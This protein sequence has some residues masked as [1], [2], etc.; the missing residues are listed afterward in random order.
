MSTT[1][2]HAQ[3]METHLTS[4]SVTL[5]LSSAIAGAIVY[6]IFLLQPGYRGDPL[7]YTIVII[8]ELFLII[9][10]I[11]TFW[12]ILSGR[13]NP[14]NFGYHAAQDNLLGGNS[15]VTIKKLNKSSPTA[16][17]LQ[18]QIYIH[19][20]MVSI[21]VFIPVYGE[22]L[23]VIQETAM[24]AKNIYGKHST[25]I[26]DD[27]KSDDV[28]LMA[29]RIGVGYLRRPDNNDAKAGNIN[30]ALANTKGEYFIIFDADFVADKH[31]IVETIPFFEDEKMAFVQTPQYYDN[32]NN[33]ISTGANYMQHVFYSLVQV[34]KNRFNASFC[35]GTNVIFRR[36]A[37]ESIGGMYFQSK[38][39]DIWTS[40]LLHEKGYRSIYINKVLAIG[41]TPETIKAYT[42]QQ[43]RW[44]TGS[45]EILLKY[46]PLRN[47][48]LT[49][50]QRIQY[51][52]TT[53]F[54]LNG[55]AIVG[56]VLLPALQIYFNLTPISLEIP[57][58]Q[59]AILYSGFY[60]TQ[61]TLSILTMGAFR[62]ETIVLSAV[63]FPIYVKA[64]MN[65]FWNRD[66]TWR[67]TNRK[68]TYDSPFNYI[69][70]QTYLFIFL[71]LTTMVGVWKS[72]YT[73]EFSISI[74]WC[75]LN[76]LI[77][78]CFIFIALR[79]S[80]TSDEKLTLPQKPTHLT[81]PKF[82]VKGRI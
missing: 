29:K 72:L 62:V 49:F 12:T 44:A 41:K 54:Y 73:Q 56:L 6:M 36:S 14:R 19:Q 79:E 21:D 68:D 27:G 80:M 71:F 35:V 52:V 63:S 43:L 18:R 4:P 34:G 16:D 30:Y 47:K 74:I 39:E 70:I 23:D 32:Q 11:V 5:L 33:F 51:L 8:A 76:A 60:M 31:F 28:A 67:A 78:G 53:S 55:F 66:E 61:L 22:P 17:S 48:K 25:I 58:Y 45:F 9:H 50:D 64:F 15:K 75:G 46:N 42:K 40:L 69:K 77:F 24:A 2:V 1:E 26:L 57:F 7:P 10:S 20:K 82:R 37:I 3:R 81:L 65:A 59:W 13:I 38:S